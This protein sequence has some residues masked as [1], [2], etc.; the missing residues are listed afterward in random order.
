MSAIQYIHPSWK[1]VQGML[2]IDP[3]KTLRDDVLTNC[4][5][6]P[7]RNDIFNAFRMP[8]SDIKVVI[9]GQDPYPNPNYACGYAFAVPPGVERKPKSL[10]IIEKEAFT[11][12]PTHVNASGEIDLHAWTDQG[13][14]LLNTALT[15]ERGKPGSHSKYW[16]PF[17]EKVI[18]YIAWKNPCIWMLWGK[19]AQSFL[20][21]IPKQ[22]H[23]NKYNSE[24]IQN[25]PIDPSRN[26]IMTSPH[27]IVEE[28]G[29][30]KFFGCNHF[31]K[32]NIILNKK[33]VPTITW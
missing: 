30:G 1:P 15:V 3:L 17:I 29:S 33:R 19:H 27:P 9:L 4:A 25:I 14:L 5:Y 21:S 6:N 2:Y 24:L 22:L 8:V 31:K 26:Y 12:D 16:K 28:Y 10:Q 7:R 20:G 32:T 11:T 13:V 18:G 23:V